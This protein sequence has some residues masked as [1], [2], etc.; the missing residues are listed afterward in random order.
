MP[1]G[2][3]RVKGTKM[4]N[5][6]AIAGV[7]LLS[8]ALVVAG[9]GQT[10]E[11][12]SVTIT[13]VPQAEVFVD[14]VSHGAS[15][16]TLSLPA[17]DHRIEFRTE[18]F[19]TFETTAALTGTETKAIEAVL[20]PLDP[21][22][23]AVVARLLE[24]EGLEVAPWVAPEVTRGRS[25]K[26]AVAVLLWPS[27]DVRLDGLV[28]FAIEA[29][30]SYGGDAS[31]EFRSDGK[32]LYRVPFNPA[33]ITSVI[34]LPAEVIE[35]AKVNSQI[36]W[37]LYF[38]DRRSP[39]KTTF[40]VVNRPNA[41]RQLERLRESRHMQRQPVITRKI[42][43]AVVLENNRLYSEALV[44]NLT[45][46]N[47]HPES[48]QPY[49]GIITTLR[50][51][52]AENSELFATI[53]PHVSGKGGRGISARG[54]ELGIGAWSPVQTG[55]LPTPIATATDAPTRATGPGGMGVTPSGGATD[56]PGATEPT[57]ATGGVEA[58]KVG[59]NADEALRLRGEL[60][61]LGTARATAEEQLGRARADATAAMDAAAT[62]ERA[63]GEA[64]AAASA[65]REVVESAAT[66]TPEQIEAMQ[67][68]NRVA[69]T[70]RAA[71]DEAVRLAR[72]SEHSASALETEVAR[73]NER[74]GDTQR[75]LDAVSSAVPARSSKK[76]VAGRGGQTHGPAP[77]ETSAQDA[78]DGAQQN[79]NAASAALES[80][81][82]ALAQAEAANA[83]GPTADT[84]RALKDA[85]E[86]HESAQTAAGRASKEFDAARKAL[87]QFNAGTSSATG[88]ATG[89]GSG[90]G[91]GK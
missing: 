72:Q 31:L 48:T 80:A 24:S 51:L 59:G 13:S 88:S 10:D 35:F 25:G 65:A 82:T 87:E 12:V 50:R 77:V 90:T 76:P 41:E 68:A 73:L 6:R 49:R 54:S 42:A 28:N 18:G 81:A 1:G 26:Q 58:P 91:H 8:L 52:D 45:I 34:P 11:N 23:P 7:S 9:C 63:A 70:A 78:F 46:A 5:L 57:P 37:G 30:E 43:E 17:G 21:S 61:V 86:A 4:R 47:E 32:V 71:A 85:R 20:E 66:A 60:E 64:E 84:E 56:A 55:A 69:E 16:Q 2:I 19:K 44:A 79:L 27:K 38:E 36:T 53:S 62:A 75:L 14:G 33:S 40:K 29:D 67:D 89:S 15:G 39:I 83:T 3:D 74:L 22:S